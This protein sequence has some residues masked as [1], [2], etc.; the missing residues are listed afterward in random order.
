MGNLGQVVARIGDQGFSAPGGVFS[1]T[2]NVRRIT[3]VTDIGPRQVVAPGQNF[4]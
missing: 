3:E 4:S 1:K 2:Q